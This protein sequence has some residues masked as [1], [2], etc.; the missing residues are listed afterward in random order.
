M[1]VSMKVF[2]FSFVALLLLFEISGLLAQERYSTLV[3][4]VVGIRFRRWLDVETEKDKVIVNFRIGHKTVY[5]PHRYPFVG[6]TVKVE[7]L[8]DRGVPIAYT[9]TILEKK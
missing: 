7:Y 6:E 1:K 5:N 4:K 2:I 9:V 8:T 3:G